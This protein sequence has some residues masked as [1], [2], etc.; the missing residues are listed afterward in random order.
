MVL[1]M[2]LRL[3]QQ[4]HRQH[5]QCCSKLWVGLVRLWQGLEIN[6]SLIPFS[7]L[8][9][10]Y[11]ELTMS[12]YWYSYNVQFYIVAFLVKRATKLLNFAPNWGLAW[13]N[14]VRLD[15]KSVFDPS[16]KTRVPL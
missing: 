15:E 13:H 4:S 2:E 11:D 10:L 9:H 6:M 7:G 5:T 16:P 3:G 1:H 8:M 12:F 14:M